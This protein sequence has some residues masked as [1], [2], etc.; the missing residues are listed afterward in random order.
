M[1]YKHITLTDDA[2]W[3]VMQKLRNTLNFLQAALVRLFVFLPREILGCLNI[4]PLLRRHRHRRQRN[5]GARR[6]AFEAY[7]PHL[8]QMFVPILDALAKEQDL[9]IDFIVMF[10]PF[11]GLRGMRQTQR[12]AHEILKIPEERI[13]RIWQVYWEKYD[14]IIC[15]DIYAK[16]PILRTHKILLP[17]G[18]GF[19]S[20][21][22]TTSLLRKSAHDFDSF[23]LVGESSNRSAKKYIRHRPQTYVVG[24]PYVD[25]LVTGATCATR[26]LGDP[27]LA[28][29][30]KRVLFA[31]HWGTAT[32]TGEQSEFSFERVMDCLISKDI[33]VILKLHAALEVKGQAHG[34]SWPQV[35]SRYEGADKVLVVH[36]MH[37]IPYFQMADL[38]ITDFSG[39][40]FCFMLTDKP[41]ILLAQ[42]ESHFEHPLKKARYEKM[43]QGSYVVKTVAELSLGLDLSLQHPGERSAARKRVVEDNFAFRGCAAAEN[44][45]TVRRLA[46]AAR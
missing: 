22:I 24:F 15:N 36:D 4:L 34:V 30:R 16:F 11:R 43:K 13:R 8:A 39:R 25:P 33:L 21:E 9:T 17:H 35:L 29:G 41:V 7:S 27:R 42:P 20:R 26:L 10:H 2:L 44:G 5:S 6:I 28:S 46:A 3:S 40:A 1:G 23:F 38:L 12:A 45:K 18:P 19:S 37:D 14:C 31:P 32:V